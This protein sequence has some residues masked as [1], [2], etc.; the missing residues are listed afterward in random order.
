M[1]TAEIKIWI[2]NDYLLYRQWQASN[3]DMDEYIAQYREGLIKYIVDK[4][5][6]IQLCDFQVINIQNL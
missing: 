6:F 2:N 4:K 5:K 3:L 1:E